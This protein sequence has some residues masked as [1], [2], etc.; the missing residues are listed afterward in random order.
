MKCGATKVKRWQGGDRLGL[1]S[2]CAWGHAGVQGVGLLEVASEGDTP[3]AAPLG[4]KASGWEP[5]ESSD[6]L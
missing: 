3:R 1:H 5:L 4:L 2:G 6:T